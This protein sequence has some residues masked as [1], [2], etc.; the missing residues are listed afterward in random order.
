MDVRNLW[1]IFIAPLDEEFQA[2]NN[3]WKRENEFS[4]WIIS[5]ISNPLWNGQP[6]KHIPMNKANQTQHV[7]FIYFKSFCF[8]CM[9]ILPAPYMCLVTL[10]T[11]KGHRFPWPGVTIWILGIKPGSSRST[12]G[13]LHNCAMFPTEQFVVTYLY[14]HLHVAINIKEKSKSQK[15]LSF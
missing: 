11:R 13:I 12:V 10:E 5:L 8:M 7:A 14:V 1:N 4:L 3:C 9:G 2:T 15:C 6:Y